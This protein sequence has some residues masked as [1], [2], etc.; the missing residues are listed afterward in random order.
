MSAI[1][2]HILH[3]RWLAVWLIALTLLMKVVVPNG[4]MLGS[5]NGTFTIE[6][7][8]GYGPV[9]MMRLDGKIDRPTLDIVFAKASRG[10]DTYLLLLACALVFC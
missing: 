8:S 5:S 10:L 7:C 6:I 2:H 3:H 1:R 4:Y 9:T